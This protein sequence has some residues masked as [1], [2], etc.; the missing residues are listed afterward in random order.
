FIRLRV[1]TDAPLTFQSVSFRHNE[2]KR[3]SF[4]TIPMTWNSLKNEKTKQTIIDIRLQDYAPLS[5]IDVKADSTRD[6][7]RPLRI[8]VVTDSFKT[9]KGWMKSY[10]TLYEGH[11]TSFRSNNFAFPWRLARE[12]RMVVTNFDD[13]P[14]II[15][16]VAVAGPK[17]NIVARLEPGNNILL[18]GF[19][20][21]GP[22]SYDLA[23]F[24][25]SIPDSLFT[26]ELASP[27]LLI[28]HDTKAEALFQNKLWL[29]TIMTIMIA[30]LGLFTIKMMKR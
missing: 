11:L 21:L 18:H 12:I 10:E 14:I 19:Q 15:R 1:K 23:Y 27:E 3:G 17:V 28:V 24:Q 7:Y 16:D 29:W 4:R 13:Q 22:A 20:G 5:F 26:A 2:V 30:G 6:Y 8:E 9:D 25:S